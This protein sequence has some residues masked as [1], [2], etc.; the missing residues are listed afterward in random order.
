M[1]TLT[2][3]VP[4]ETTNRCT[5]PSVERD[6]TGWASS[7][8][9]T[10]E[11]ST[12]WQA[13]GAWAARA[14]ADGVGDQIQAP[15][16]TP[17]GD[18]TITARIKVVTGVWKA[19][20]GTVEQTGMGPGEHRVELIGSGTTSIRLALEATN[21]DG[22]AE[23]LV[24]GVQ[25]EDKDHS[26]TYCDGDQ[27]GGT[28]KAGDHSSTS[29]RKATTRAGGKEITFRGLNL[30]S[31]ATVGGA[32]MPPL[33]HVT[34]GLGLADGELLQR[35]IADPAVL[36]FRTTLQG[37]DLAELLSRR[38]ELVDAVK[39][40]RVP[41]SAEPLL[42]TYDGSG[43]EYEIEAVYLQG[44]EG[45]VNPGFAEELTLQ[46]VAYDPKW[47][48]RTDEGRSVPV[49]SD[50]YFAGNIIRRV[51]GEWLPM[52]MG[53]GADVHA[54]EQGPDGRI[55]VG[56]DFTTVNRSDWT[57]V[58][59]NGIAAWDPETE[60]WSALGAGIDDGLVRRIAFDGD[61]NLYITGTFTSVAGLANTRG[62]A[63]W[64]GSSW[65]AIGGGCDDGDTDALVLDRE[66]N[67]V[68]G[69][70]FTAVDG[71]TQARRAAIWDGV[72]W[73]ELGDGFNSSVS[74]GILHPSGDV[75]LCGAFN[76]DGPGSTDLVHVA[77]WD[78]STVSQVGNG[79][80]NSALDLVLGPDGLIY[81][82]GVFTASGSGQTL[83]R[84]ARL[85]GE[86]WRP[87]GD[88]LNGEA[89]RLDFDDDGLL[90][91]G[92][93]FTE[94]GGLDLAER[95][96]LWTGTAWAQAP[97]DLPPQFSPQLRAVLPTP[98]TLYLGFTVGGNTITSALSTWKNGGSSEAPPVIELVGPGHLS[99]IRNWTTGTE[100]RFD[101]PMQ[102]GERVTID[103][104][105][106]RTTVRSSRRGNVASDA[107]PGAEIGGLRLAPGDN[108]L[109]VFVRDAY[110]VPV[111]A[112]TNEGSDSTATI[113]VP[114]GVETDDLLYAVLAV[115][116]GSDAGITAPSGWTLVRRTDNGTTNAQAIYRKWVDDPADETSYTWTLDTSRKHRVG[117]LILRNVDRSSPV[118]FESSQ[119]VNGIPDSTA[120]AVT[121]SRER[122]SVLATWTGEH[123]ATGAQ[124]IGSL[125]TSVEMSL[126][127]FDDVAS[128]VIGATGIRFLA[129]VDEAFTP[130]GS[131]D[132]NLTG[133]AHTALLRAASPEV[134]A[135]AWW[136]PRHWG[137]E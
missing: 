93:A 56:G 9:S 14:V 37:G 51:D 101:L 74:G 50:V 30:R 84:I 118:V 8:L 7:G 16:F 79:L 63:K 4:E 105:P 35:T 25:Y 5:N 83:N 28:W 122:L 121:P 1:A 96:A 45:S 100:A 132:F 22:T 106:G 82:A 2:V 41:N 120:P 97:I 91:V 89:T 114:N 69:G 38:R 87:L 49:C 98:D 24:D 128:P 43:E 133:V 75:Y 60:T 44:L 116:G 66:E 19:T 47:R 103:L 99:E 129:D 110:I 65:S 104:R 136:R 135:Y 119:E 32:G 57:S 127:D 85:E 18:Y 92:G 76:K 33:R 70:S 21:V 67:V 134:A 34:Q 81:V 15:S 112:N 78:G 95:Y 124:A 72:S 10:F 107:L 59:V 39:P 54:I 77:K 102:A 27:T 58:T 115:D 40:D 125:N 52:G 61:G 23:V 109:S 117:I 17:D 130:E 46:F 42:L 68:I 36:T 12:D 113:N 88:G 11:R 64:D 3:I 55:Y 53:T 123:D 62:I 126:T 94:A 108:D 48:K 71:G 131:H 137:A 86:A 26:T 6:L 73:A 13:F 31:P 111:N 90:H 20:D 29:T 80:D